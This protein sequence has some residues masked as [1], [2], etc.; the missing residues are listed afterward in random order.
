MKFS[1]VAALGLLSFATETA[2]A[3]KV[4]SFGAS[5]STYCWRAKVWKKLQDNNIKDLDF[6][7][8]QKGKDC[9]FTYDGDNEGYPGTKATE[10]ASNGKLVGYLNASK[11]DVVFMLLGTND[12]LIDKRPTQDIINAYNTLIDQMRASKSNMK[13]VVSQLTP[14]DPARF[15]QTA[16]DGIKALNTAIATWA[17]TKST[18]TSPIFVVDNF[19]GFDAVKDTVEGE[20]PNDSGNEKIANKVYPVLVQAYRSASGS[21]GARKYRVEW[22]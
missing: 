16:A 17:P 10:F 12:V 14:L 9:G 18:R 3:V 19:T 5:I 11:P 15:P 13:I 2:A 8:S 1:A 21:F 22:N 6:V 7:G 20:H 4:M